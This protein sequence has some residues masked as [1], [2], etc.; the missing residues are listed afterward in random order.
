MKYSNEMKVGVTLIVATVVFVLGVRFFQDLPLFK[1]TYSLVSE[2]DN[3][4]GLIS[5]NLV[6]INGVG[7]GS[8]DDV[9]I[10]PETQRVRVEF[11][12]GLGIP[13]T[14]GSTSQIAGFEALGVV[15]LDLVLGPP[16][17]S[18]Y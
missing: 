9:Y 10:N 12:I 1:G 17:R 5:G 2:F 4:G 8:V 16:K 13:V 3:A 15:R 18:S 6:R 11:H 7:V 14:R